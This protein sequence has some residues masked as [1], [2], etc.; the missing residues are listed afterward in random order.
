MAKFHDL[1]DS[2]GVQ[3]DGVSLAY[4]DT[5]RDDLTAAYDE[6]FSVPSAKIQVLESEN[7]ELKAQ[8]AGL[9]AHNYDLLMSGPAEPSDDDPVDDAT[10]PDGDNPD[11]GDDKGVDGLFSKA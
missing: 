11:D 6:D 10:T 4:P 2:L 5:F 1:F 8:I 7:A 9:K 3:E